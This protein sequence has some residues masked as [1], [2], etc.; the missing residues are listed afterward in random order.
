MGKMKQHKYII[1][2]IL[3]LTIL[4]GTFYWFQLK[5]TQASIVSEIPKGT[6][7]PT[8]I[9]DYIKDLESEN[10]P[11]IGKLPTEE[12]ILNSPHIKQI[13]IALNGYLDGTNTGLEDSAL[14]VT[15]DEMKC[16]L[17][18]FSKIYYRSK[19]VILSASDNDYGGVQVFLVFVDKPDTVFWAWVYGI[20]GEQRLR[21]F[22][23]KPPLKSERAEF[24]AFIDDAIKNAKYYL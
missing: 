24:R 5:Q 16:G 23:E 6:V 17:N 8:K 21:T 12:E 18:N 19:F 7:D 11:R 10:P 13:R 2:T 20:S 15:S 1:I 22:C 3:I 9:A 14:N 4:G